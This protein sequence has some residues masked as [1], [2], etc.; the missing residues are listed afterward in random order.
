MSTAHGYTEIDD[1]DLIA[2][3]NL[4]REDRN[5]ESSAHEMP[6]TKS[7]GRASARTVFPKV[8]SAE[9]P[10]KGWTTGSSTGLIAT[11][12]DT[13]LSRIRSY[14]PSVK[15]IIGTGLVVLFLLNPVS[16]I[17]W[18]LVGAVFMLSLYMIAGEE[19][20]CRSLAAVHARYERI[21]AKSARVLG[22]RCR[23]A[24][25]KW[26]RWVSILPQRMADTLQAPDFRAVM[27]AEIRRDA[28]LEDRLKRLNSD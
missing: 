8:R 15:A 17:G 28:A 1:A 19:R 16:V 4:L 21:N 24:A 23:L 25:R 2:I 7:A 12:K 10:A 20:V 22:V 13:A 3:R 18:T 5:S 9:A 11:F 27:R 26:N 6:E 14:R